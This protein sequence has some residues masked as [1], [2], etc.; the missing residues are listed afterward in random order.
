MKPLLFVTGAGGFI[1]ARLVARLCAA[2]WRVRALVRQAPAEGLA[3]AEIVL[4]DLERP[5]SYAHALDDVDTLIHL[6]AITGSAPPARFRRVNVEGSAALIAAAK[7]AGV[8]RIAFISSIAAG[9]ANKRFYPYARSKEE[10]EALVAAS[11]LAFAILRPTIV[12]AAEAPI[13]ASI[14]RIAR[15]PLIP[16]PQGARPVRV[17]PVHVD[18]VVRAIEIVLDREAF[19]GETL[20]VGGPD[21]EYFADFLQ[22]VRRALTGSAPPVVRAPAGP[23][24]YALACMEPAL[25]PLLPMTAGQLALFVNDSDARPSWLMEALRPGMPSA[26]ALVRRLTA[27][28]DEPPPPPAPSQ[29]PPP[30]TAAL[31]AEGDVFTRYL[32]GAG[33]GDA[34]AAHYARAMAARGLADDAAFT[35]FDRICLAF[36]RSGPFQARCADAYCA[37]LARGGALRRKL[38]ALAAILESRAPASDLFDRPA[39]TSPI[40]AALALIPLG[41]AFAGSFLI[42][43]AVLT[44]KRLFMARQAPA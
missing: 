34:V 23:V 29:S 32:T 17:Q 1:G 2:G 30:D 24:R 20:D 7:A 41:A 37:L 43:F 42:G 18:D 13:W 40:G 19:A 12:L 9:Y 4:G 14:T 15:L 21:P 6:A 22:E 25:R 28:A 3:D 11:G 44:G 36:A 10:A 27:R 5:E 16:L 31:R 39:Q 33:A 26:K 8:R 35:P 38:V